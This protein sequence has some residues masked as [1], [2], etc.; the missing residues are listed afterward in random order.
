[1]H[2]KVGGEAV[3]AQAIHA[4][5]MVTTVNG[6]KQKKRTGVDLLFRLPRAERDWI[7]VGSKW[8]E[9][10]IRRSAS[11]QL[12]K[13]SSVRKADCCCVDKTRCHVRRH[14]HRERSCCSIDQA[15]TLADAEG[16][17]GGVVVGSY[18]RSIWK[19]RKI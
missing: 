7:L 18:H 17:A 13:S 16:C 12:L 4:H 8:D 10:E 15:R 19:S 9:E 1:M 14:D 5:T 6:R 2:K 11:R 3:S